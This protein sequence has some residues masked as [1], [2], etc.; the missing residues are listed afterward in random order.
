M[1][2]KGV[3][4]QRSSENIIWFVLKSQTCTISVLPSNL[5]KAPRTAFKRMNF[6]QLLGSHL[7]LHPQALFL[8]W[9]LREHQVG[10]GKGIFRGKTRMQYKAKNSSARQSVLWKEQGY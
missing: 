4:L 8:L 6:K 2:S 9:K 7:R 5:F 3:Q 10:G 1:A